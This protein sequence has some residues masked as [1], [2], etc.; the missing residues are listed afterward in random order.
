MFKQTQSNVQTLFCLLL[1]LQSLK[2]PDSKTKARCIVGSGMS[3]IFF[4]L[5]PLMHHHFSPPPQ[6]L[7]YYW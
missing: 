6:V 7:L 3:Q 5:L 4:L 2:L 1:Q